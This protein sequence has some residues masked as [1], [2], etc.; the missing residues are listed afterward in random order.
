MFMGAFYQVPDQT[1]QSFALRNIEDPKYVGQARNFD[2]FKSWL[3]QSSTKRASPTSSYYTSKNDE[4]TL[5]SWRQRSSNKRW[6]LISKGMMSNNTH[7]APRW[8]QFDSNTQVTWVTCNSDNFRTQFAAALQSYANI[9]GITFTYTL[10]GSTATTGGLGTQDGKNALAFGDPQNEIPGSFS[11]TTGGIVAKGGPKFQTSQQSFRGTVWNPTVEGDIVIQDGV[12]TCSFFQTPDIEEFLCH[13]S[14]HTLGLGHSCG[15]TDSGPCTTNSPQDVALMRAL[16]HF[17]QRGPI[18][19]P[20]DINGLEYLYC[21]VGTNC[22]TSVT[23][24]GT[25]SPSPTGTGTGTGPVHTSG[26]PGAT[27]KPATTSDE[28][29]T[30]AQTASG[31]SLRPSIWGIEVPKWD[32]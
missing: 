17:D 21:K 6:T 26:S 3:S 24:A 10:G 15:D 32:W 18:I 11:C 23:G 30:S 2:L 7:P 14:G 31:S 12:E 28:F 27:T 13:E 4:L 1:G 22:V 5:N 8:F 29:G 20:D 9:V 16:G 19:T 25:G